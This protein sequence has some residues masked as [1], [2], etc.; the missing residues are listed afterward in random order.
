MKLGIG[1]RH[2]LAHF[3]D[4][5]PQIDFVELLAED[6]DVDRPLPL[7]LRRLLDRGVKTVVH[8]VSVSLGSADGADL[9]AARHLARVAEK[10]SAALVSEHLSFSRAGGMESGH[11]LP[12]PRN[13]ASVTLLAQNVAR[14]KKIVKRPLALENIASFVRWPN[15]ELDEPQFVEQVLHETGCGLLLDLSNLY[16]NAV[17]FSADP[18]GVLTAFPTGR[19][20]YC[21]I[22]GGVQHGGLYHDT[23]AHPLQRGPLELLRELASR[24]I[25]PPILLER[26]DQ[27]P[28]A[29][30]MNAELS[31]IAQAA[32]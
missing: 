16:A 23:H 5:A 8:S 3:I 14:V 24:G 26:D 20:A 25:R 19:V 30:Q 4:H 21:H 18:L 1:W 31:A 7:P 12:M 27:F 29:P 28:R 11:L 32:R 9:D 6:I 10:V 17:N 2:A 13:G 15:D 22:A